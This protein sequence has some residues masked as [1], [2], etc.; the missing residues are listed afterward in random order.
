M[1]EGLPVQVNYLADEGVSCGKGP[2]VV[3]SYIHHFLENYGIGEQHLQLNADNCA[4]QNKNNLMMQYLSWRVFSEL[5]T[6]VALS[7]LMVEHTKFAPDWCFGLVKRRYRRTFVS[8]LQD[9]VDVVDSS[10][11]KGINISQL[12]GNESG[13]VFV[14]VYDWS[15]HLAGH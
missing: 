13:D 12:V 8:S 14:P 3:I 9:I 11:Q 10:T 7:F 2:N 4:G 1:A 15:S 6:S 5:N